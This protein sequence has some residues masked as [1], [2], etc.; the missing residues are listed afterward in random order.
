MKAFRF[1]LDQ[2]L[3]WRATQVDLE[4]SRAAVA[5]TRLANLRARAEASR[6]ELKES[7][8]QL[9]TGSELQSLAIRR[10]RMRRQILD[11]EKQAKEAEQALAERM[12]LLVEA[13]R[14]HLLL[15]NLRQTEQARW[16]SAF[17]RELEAF[18]GE[19]FLGRL[20]SKSGRAR[21]SGG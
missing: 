2:A 5:A 7:P 11:I 6:R 12:K 21:S 9:T 1:R 16:Q 10:D 18:A 15:E 4:K 19:A 8:P 17:T 3:R 20:Q 14:K 13:N